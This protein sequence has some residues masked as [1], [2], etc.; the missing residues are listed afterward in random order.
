MVLRGRQ[1][2]GRLAAV[3][4]WPDLHLLASVHCFLSNASNPGRGSFLDFLLADFL[5][6]RFAINELYEQYNFWWITGHL[7]SSARFSH[8]YFHHSYQH[9]SEIIFKYF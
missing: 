9:G 6:I 3:L 2:G 7:I 8:S 5:A 1:D 4:P